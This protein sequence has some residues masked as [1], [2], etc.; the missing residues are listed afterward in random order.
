[1]QTRQGESDMAQ[2]EC[3]V[4]AVTPSG[5]AL[6]KALAEAAAWWPTS[7]G[8]HECR[9]LADQ[10]IASGAVV[11]LDTLADDEALVGAWARR[12]VDR[13]AYDWDRLSEGGK[14]A[15]RVR[16]EFDL[17]AF[18]AALSERGDR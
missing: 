15:Y 3:G 13:T 14:D 11:P 12:I 18:A 10:L 9:D 4:T 5:E 6:A 17:R 1:V 16:A 8:P 2:E 7:L